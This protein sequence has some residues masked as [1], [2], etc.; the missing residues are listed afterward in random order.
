MSGILMTQN[1]TIVVYASEDKRTVI[2]TTPWGREEGTPERALNYAA[3]IRREHPGFADAVAESI[4]EAAYMCI[5][6]RGNIVLN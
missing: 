3:Q 2:V 1:D 6:E 4:E 5:K